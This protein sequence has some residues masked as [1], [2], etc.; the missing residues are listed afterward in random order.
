MATV[1]LDEVLLVAAVLFGLGLLGVLIRRDVVFVLMSLEIMLNAAILAFAAAGARW[2]QA[3]GQ[4]WVVFI[5]VTA[6]AEV[7]VA[8]PLLLRLNRPG[9]LVDTDALRREAEE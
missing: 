3:D 4:V 6:A 9:P 7:A 8:L 2:H 1:P 5:L